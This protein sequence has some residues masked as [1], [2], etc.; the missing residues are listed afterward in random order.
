MLTGSLFLQVFCEQNEW[1][2]WQVNN[3]LIFY[4][5][6]FLKYFS[7][8]QLFYGFFLIYIYAS[9]II[10]FTTAGNEYAQAGFNFKFG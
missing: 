6:E 1:H 3:R 9:C 2:I 5:V 8:L 10:L 4:Q 7:C